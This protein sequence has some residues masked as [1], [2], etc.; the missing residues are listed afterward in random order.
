M[1]KSSYIQQLN[2]TLIGLEFVRLTRLTYSFAD[3]TWTKKF[4]N[5]I[6]VVEFVDKTTSGGGYMFHASFRGESNNESFASLDT[7]PSNEQELFIH[8]KV[9]E[10]IVSDWK[11]L[12]D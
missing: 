11:R 3:I 12:N 1:D 2:D 4:N 6:S 10:E 8:I 7:Y 5:V 9:C